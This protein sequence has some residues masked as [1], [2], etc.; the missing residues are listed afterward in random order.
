M[1]GMAK[2]WIGSAVPLLLLLPVAALWGDAGEY[3]RAKQKLENIE[4]MP[5][6]SQVM[7]TASELNAY[8]AGEIPRVAGQGAVSNARL[9]L[10]DNSGVIQARVNFLRLQQNTGQRPGWLMRM[11]LD[12]ERDVAVAAHVRSG[13]G[14]ATVWV[15]RLDISGVPVSGAALDFLMQ[16]FVAPEFPNVKIGEPFALRRGVERFEVGPQ[17]VRVFL[18]R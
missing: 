16:V 1:R 12:G 6:G 5:R 11:V 3:W 17:A 18:R 8:I 15:D 7:L 10:G 9:Q 13:G 4:R 2:K 14:T